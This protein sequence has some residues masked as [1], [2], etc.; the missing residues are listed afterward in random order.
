MERA[1]G[2]NFPVCLASFVPL[3]FV[4]F[5]FCFVLFCFVFFL[6]SRRCLL[7]ER[8]E[9]PT[10][11]RT[12]RI[13]GFSFKIKVL[14]D[15]FAGQVDSFFIRTFFIRTF[16]AQTIQKLTKLDVLIT[17]G[18]CKALEGSRSIYEMQYI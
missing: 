5:V 8:L 11:A 2:K 12:Y 4:L 1:A 7:T 15:N 6:L 16:Q 13:S 3:F 18:V 14:R 17:K 9:Q 10:T